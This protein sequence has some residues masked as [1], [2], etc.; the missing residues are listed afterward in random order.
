[1][2]VHIYR[3][4]III[5]LIHCTESSYYMILLAHNIMY[6][7]VTIR[8]C[9]SV[10]KTI[11]SLCSS[12]FLMERIFARAAHIIPDNFHIYDRICI[13]Y[14]DRCGGCWETRRSLHIRAQ[15]NNILYGITYYFSL[16]LA[17]SSP[18]PRADEFNCNVVLRAFSTRQ[19]NDDGRLYSHRITYHILYYYF[20]FSKSP[21]YIIIY[22][23]ARDRELDLGLHKPR[24]LGPQMQ[25]K[26]RTKIF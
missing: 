2:Q 13:I 3:P 24:I 7:L 22:R 10:S 5:F 6:A 21:Y 26:H 9:R 23:R 11:I 8:S 12:Q 4:V 14:T 1:M 19:F 16:S 18:L 20:S 25:L 15:Y 17:R